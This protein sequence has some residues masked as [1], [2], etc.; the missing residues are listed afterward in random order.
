MVQLCT[1]RLCMGRA[2]CRR[3]AGQA[4][5]SGSAFAYRCS[6]IQVCACTYVCA[7]ICICVYVCAWL[8]MRGRVCHPWLASPI[9]GAEGA[10]EGRSKD[11]PPN[12]VLAPC[13]PM[14]TPQV[15]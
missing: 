1:G 7:C 3:S 10:G 12:P 6:C 4:R 8:C 15:L 13:T 2:G 5:V 9:C 14:A 11:I